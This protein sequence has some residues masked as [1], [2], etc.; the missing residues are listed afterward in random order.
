[1]TCSYGASCAG[2]AITVCNFF[3]TIATVLT[4]V[5]A[6]GAEGAGVAPFLSEVAELQPKTVIINTE[7]AKSRPF[8]VQPPRIVQTICYWGLQDPVSATQSMHCAV[9]DQKPSGEERAL[10]RSQLQDHR[11]PRAPEEPS[12][13]FLDRRQ[14]PLGSFPQSWQDS[15]STLDV[16]AL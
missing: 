1:S 12:L 9:P 10:R 3:D 13:R 6:F 7:E 16:A 4:V 14:A 5:G 11:S 15:S 8:I 2:N